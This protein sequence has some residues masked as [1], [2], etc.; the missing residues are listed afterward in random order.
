M[1]ASMERL[2]GELQVRAI[3]GL[4]QNDLRGVGEPLDLYR[5]GHHRSDIRFL[6]RERDRDGH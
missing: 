4:V 2:Q 6:C 3:T 1:E 5:T